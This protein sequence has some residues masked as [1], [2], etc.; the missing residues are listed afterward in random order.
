MVLVDG[1]YV[2]PTAL[3]LVATV[4][5][6]GYSLRFISNVFLGPS[7]LGEIKKTSLEVPRFM[8]LAMIILTVFVVIIGIYPSLFMNLINTIPFT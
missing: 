5:S 3:M 4:L 2:W 6:L 1:F 8:L 7:K